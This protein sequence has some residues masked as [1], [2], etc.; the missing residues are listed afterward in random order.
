MAQRF[1]SENRRRPFGAFSHL[2]VGGSDR[3]V[4]PSD[5]PAPLSRT[6]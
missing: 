1:D 5:R 4:Y 6:A 3:V 2:A